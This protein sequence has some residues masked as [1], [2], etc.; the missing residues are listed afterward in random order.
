MMRTPDGE[1]NIELVKFHKPLDENGIQHP[2]ANT[3][4]I[5]HIAFAVEDIEALV[6]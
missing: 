4:G 2:L 1:A 5:R 3:L 6:T